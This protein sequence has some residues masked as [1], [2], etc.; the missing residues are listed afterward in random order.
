MKFHFIIKNEQNERGSNLKIKRM[1]KN[2]YI[3]INRFI[4]GWIKEERD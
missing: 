3:G 2:R 1:D 4:E